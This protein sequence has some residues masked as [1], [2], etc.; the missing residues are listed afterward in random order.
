MNTLFKGSQGEGATSDRDIRIVEA[1]KGYVRY[2]RVS[3]G[4]EW[5]VRGTCEGRG[6]C[7]VGVVVQTPSGPI[8]IRDLAHLEELKAALGRVRIDVGEDEQDLDVP[9]MPG[10]ENDGCCPLI[11]TWL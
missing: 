1:R 9:V 8:Q 6:L 10:F 3:T 2:R 4:Q 11:G 5:E 7:L